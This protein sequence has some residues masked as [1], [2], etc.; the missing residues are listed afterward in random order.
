M[1][2]GY[3]CGSTLC[4]SSFVECKVYGKGGVLP[5]TKGGLFFTG[6]NLIVKGGERGLLVQDI[7]SWQPGI[8]LRIVALLASS[9]T[10]AHIHCGDKP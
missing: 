8:S 7:V 4:C 6:T 10:R 2:G 5:I 1:G 9:A 3:K